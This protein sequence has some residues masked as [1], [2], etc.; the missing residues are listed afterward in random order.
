M[1][2]QKIKIESEYDKQFKENHPFYPIRVTKEK[3]EKFINRKQE[4]SQ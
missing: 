3:D 4:T 1:Q 2:R